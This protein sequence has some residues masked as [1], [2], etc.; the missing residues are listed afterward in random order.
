MSRVR[1]HEALGVLHVAE[2]DIEVPG[3]TGDPSAWLRA[4]AMAALVC[5]ADGEVLRRI[6]GVI[7]RVRERARVEGATR[8]GVTLE[9]PLAALRWSRDHRIFQ[10]STTEDIVSTLLEEHGVAAAAVEWR[11]SATYPTRE[12]CTQLGEETLSFVTRILEEDGIFHFVEHREDGTVVVFGDSASAYA[13]TTPAEVLFHT[14][15]LLTERGVRELALV[16]E[17]RPAKVTLRDHDFKRPAL[18]LEASVS[19]AS[20]LER[21]HYDYPG[22]YQEPDEGKRRAQLRLEAMIAAASTASGSGDVVGFT[23]G[24]T[25]TL[26]GAPD[27]ALDGE[28]VVR[29]VEH[30]WDQRHGLGNRFQLLRK[31]LPFRPPATVPEVDVPGPQLA[32]VTGPAGEEI[33]CDEHGRIKVSFP[34]DRRSTRDDKSSCWVRVAQMHTSGSVVI[35]RIGWEVV[36][37]YENGDPDRPI[38]MGR[39][40]NGTYGPP[41]PLPAGKTKSALQ[42]ASSPGGGGHNEIRMEDSGGGEQ[43]HV[44][45]EKDLNVV[46]AN[47]K[48]EKVTNNAT[49]GVGSN[50]SL[51]VGANST[52]DVGISEELNVG[53]SQT[54]SV[55]ASRTRTVSGEEKEDVTGSR[56]MT[57]AGSHTT[58]AAMSVTASTPAAYSETVGGSGI[59]AAALG[60]STM[61]AGSMSMTVGGAKIAACA[62][63]ATFFT[64]GAKANTV[65]GAFISASGK[66]VGMN[67]SGA[68]ATTVGGAWSANAG[69]KID[70]SS[71]AA[72]K[73]TVGGAISLNA[74]KRCSRS[75]DPASPWPPAGWC[76][77]HRRSSSP[78]PGHSPSSRPPSRKS[79]EKR[80]HLCRSSTRRSS[81]PASPP[82]TPRP[83]R[84]RWTC[85]RHRR[86]AARCPCPTPA[87][88]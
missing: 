51:T 59:E 58:M 88:P 7:T 1:L 74:S 41:Y 85:A 76:S 83:P 69:G 29:E 8:V 31:D 66:D 63:G 77:S 25:F 30:E 68:K 32:I 37:D 3:L 4:P 75:G 71:G 5:V 2:L 43:V 11:L 26:A 34:W 64:V 55:G 42:S 21:E 14:S 50:H 45:A 79:S 73:V 81:V 19:A 80:S 12:V 84:A 44:H 10:E 47:N 62:T 15:D 87:S 70:I 36:V 49:N 27:S 24:H 33:H 23:A 17:V 78:P 67:V 54:W 48:T 86:P 9:S 39:L 13:A 38:V 61:V 18:D 56:T 35:P 16:E 22:R 53:G 60:V 82:V 40:Y 6:G 46:V 57:I 65:G 72:L 20:A 52:H 28:W